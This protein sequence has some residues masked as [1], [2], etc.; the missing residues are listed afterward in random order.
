MN[1]KRPKGIMTQWRWQWAKNNVILKRKTTA[2]Q[3]DC[4]TVGFFLKIGL[5]QL[6]SLTPEAR[7][8]Q[9]KSVSP[10]SRT[11]F[12]ALLQTFCLTDR[13]YLNPKIWTVLQSTLQVNNTFFIIIYNVKRSNATWRQG[14][15]ISCLVVNLGVV[16]KK[17]LSTETFGYI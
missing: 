7:Q 5:A 8:A 12:S 14:Q 17:S 4:K 11:P 2:L 13:E 9:K 16:L 1:G 3:V 10:Q 6:N 15:R